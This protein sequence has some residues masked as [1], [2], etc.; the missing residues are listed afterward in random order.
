VVILSDNTPL[1]AA[2][3]GPT[4]LSIPWALEDYLDL[5]AEAAAK[6]E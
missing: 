5:S 1:A 6:V 4:V 2:T 3:S